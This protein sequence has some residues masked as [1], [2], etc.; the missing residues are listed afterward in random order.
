MF[1]NVTLSAYASRPAIRDHV[2][3]AVFE[4]MYAANFG[5]L[6]CTPQV[7]MLTTCPNRRARIARQ[8][9][10]RQPHRPEVVDRHG[11]LEVVEPVVGQVQ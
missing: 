10:H 8:Q 7:T 2:S 1:V 5:A 3:S 11:P 4:A 9:P 6:T